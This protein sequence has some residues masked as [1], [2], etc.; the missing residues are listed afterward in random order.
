MKQMGPRSL[1]NSSVEETDGHLSYYD[2]MSPLL[3]SS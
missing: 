1:T 2:A 3:R